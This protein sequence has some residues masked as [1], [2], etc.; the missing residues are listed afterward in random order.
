MK[1]SKKVF[2]IHFLY[3]W[4]ENDSI[5][6]RYLKIKCKTDDTPLFKKVYL[7]KRLKNIYETLKHQVYK[8]NIKHFINVYF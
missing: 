4:S 2:K 3:Q 1:Y 6:L 7:Y 8:G 5:V